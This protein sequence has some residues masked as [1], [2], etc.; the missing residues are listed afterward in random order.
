[1]L[2]IVLNLFM[3][4]IQYYMFVIFDI[5]TSEKLEMSPVFMEKRRSWSQFLFTREQTGTIDY[6]ILNW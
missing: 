1:M 5:D 2:S 3:L 6:E 4:S